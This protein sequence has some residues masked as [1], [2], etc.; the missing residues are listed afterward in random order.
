MHIVK[1]NKGGNMVETSKN[2]WTKD[3]I[4]MLLSNLFIYLAFYMLTP[5]LPAYAKLSGGSNLESS[6]VV[7]TFSITSLLVRLFAGS[8]MDKF[9]IK[10]LLAIGAVI[11]ALTT[12]SYNW[13][14]ID[15]I[16]FMRILQGIGWGLASIGAAALFSNIIPEN[17]RGEGMGYY[18][19]SMIIS[20]ALSPVIS[21]IIMNAYGFKNIVFISIFLV[22]LG[23]LSL[24]MVKV[25]R[26]Q[27]TSNSIK[28]INLKDAFEKKAALPSLLC[29][30]LTVT[31]C[32]IMSY[33]MLYGKELKLTNIWIYF[34]GFV[35]MVLVTRPVIG[36]I[37]DKKGHVVLIMPGAVSLI[38]GLVILSYGHSIGVILVSSL[39]YGLGY[40]AVQPSLQAWAVNRSPSNR[41]GA[42]N[43]TFLSSMDLA[44]GF[45][46]RFSAIFIVLLL[47]IYSYN[48]IK[49]NNAAVL[50]EK[51][52]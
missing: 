44:Y 28:K 2:L 38:I 32:G 26:L 39:F 15:A 40:G 36:K 30:L 14:S 34:M 48:V 24:R 1:I 19:L 4:F 27:T 18:S 23:I 37:F 11:L 12:L 41:K 42:A 13:L 20:M 43:G 5:T 29:F 17:K 45:M 6:L 7:S 10:P 51:V 46:Y 22:A 3:Y 50:K 31:L 35:A 8:I 16:I 9:S 33:I 49:H 25:E 21:I 47:V 52:S